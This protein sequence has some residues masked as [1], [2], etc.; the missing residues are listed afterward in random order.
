MLLVM[1]MR[2]SEIQSITFSSEYVGIKS[3]KI[4][5]SDF[6][7]SS[8]LLLSPTSGEDEEISINK[9]S[10]IIATEF[11]GSALVTVPYIFFSLL[12]TYGRFPE[13]ADYRG[14]YIGY[15]I[16]SPVIASVSIGFV[17]IAWKKKG[18]F[19]RSLMGGFV[20]SSLGTV[21]CRVYVFGSVEGSEIVEDI[22]GWSVFLLPSIGAT[23][24]NNL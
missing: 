7:Y 4:N 14:L 16:G 15:L 5:C 8:S 9:N 18:N 23:I 3:S 24:G 19:L 2:L 17:D 6:S 21:L 10:I 22:I 11:I 1:L 12:Y 13:P 20:G